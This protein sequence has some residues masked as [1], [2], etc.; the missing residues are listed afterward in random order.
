MAV[1]VDSQGELLNQI[2]F[3]VSQSVAYTTDG[4]KELKKAVEYQK[5]SRKA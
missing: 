2:E 4:V 5:K 1:L 3:N